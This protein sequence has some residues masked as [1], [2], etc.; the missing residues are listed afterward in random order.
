MGRLYPV[1]VCALVLCGFIFSKEQIFIPI[2]VLMACL[3]FWVCR[4]VKP[5]ITPLC[6][7]IYSLS[8]NNTIFGSDSSDYY[9]TGWRIKAM[10]LLGI[11]AAVSIIA[12][13]HR[14]RIIRKMMVKKTPLLFPLILFCLSLVFCGV[15]SDKWVIKDMLY[16]S[17]QVLSFL[18]VYV[19]FYHGLDDEEDATSLGDYFSF[20]TLLMSIVLIVEMVWLYTSGEG[21]I[22]DGEIVKDSIVFGWG[23]CNNAGVYLSM[24]IPMSFYGAHRSRFPIVYFFV[25]T[26][27]YLAAILTLSRNALLFGTIAYLSCLI[28]FALFERGRRRIFFAYGALA[29]LLCT[30]V[31]FIVYRET[32]LLALSSYA[33][34]GSTDAGR[35]EI[36]RA[37]I[38]SF[39][40]NPIFGNGFHQGLET[41]DIKATF[42]PAMAHNTVFQLLSASGVVGLATYALYRLCSLRAFLRRPELMKTMLGAAMLVLLCESMLDNFIFQIHPVFYYS[43]AMAIVYRRYSEQ[44]LWCPLIKAEEKRIGRW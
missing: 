35:F 27:T 16:G 21:V 12:F 24:L 14:S 41:G 32:L 40:E 39:L 7:F 33:D 30:A 17:F 18:V 31:V 34:Q 9:F 8:N 43:I 26:A 22:V 1:L 5:L 6:T 11:L 44:E 3:A 13:F 36:W 10:F 19:M 4:S 20:V 23:S 15:L 25:A 2:I 29:V 37:A 28:G 38:S 42:I